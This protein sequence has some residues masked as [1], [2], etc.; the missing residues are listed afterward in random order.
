M[1]S[2]PRLGD[3]D[4]DQ[5]QE[6]AWPGRDS[7]VGALVTQP[8]EHW[9]TCA[10]LVCAERREHWRRLGRRPLPAIDWR[11]KPLGGREL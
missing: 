11:G 9:L 1:G 8:G 5:R 3:R 7:L 10:C 6:P 4:R 2:H